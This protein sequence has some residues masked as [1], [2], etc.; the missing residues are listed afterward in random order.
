MQLNDYREKLDKII[1]VINTTGEERKRK[2]E[3][4]QIALGKVKECIDKGLNIQ[5]ELENALNDVI[6]QENL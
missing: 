6:E 2:L 3:E 5:T 1:T 4:I